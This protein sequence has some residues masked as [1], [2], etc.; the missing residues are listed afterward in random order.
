MFLK[1]QEYT[2]EIELT[3]QSLMRLTEINHINPDRIHVT[4]LLTQYSYP[5]V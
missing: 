5:F 2:F 1:Q 4:Y 3:I